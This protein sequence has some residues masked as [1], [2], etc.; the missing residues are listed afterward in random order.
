MTLSQAALSEL[1]EAFQEW[2][3]CRC[4]WPRIC[5]GGAVPSDCIVGGL[6]A[7]GFDAVVWGAVVTWLRLHAAGPAPTPGTGSRR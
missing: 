5:E 7:A 1:L 6:M 2:E 4:S 3:W